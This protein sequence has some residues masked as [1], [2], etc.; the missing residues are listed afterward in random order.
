MKTY[1]NRQAPNLHSIVIPFLNA[2]GESDDDLFDDCPVC[3][4]LKKQ[5][6]SGELEEIS[7]P[8]DL[9]GDDEDPVRD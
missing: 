6:E 1:K 9:E 3:Q 7:I 2:K 4:L 8:I 5:I